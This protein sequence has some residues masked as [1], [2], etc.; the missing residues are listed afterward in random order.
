M[1]LE[2]DINTCGDMNRDGVPSLWWGTSS[3]LAKDDT[4]A[5]APDAGGAEEEAEIRTV[6]GLSSSSGCESEYMVGI[7]SVSALTLSS[8]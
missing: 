4:E 6:T 3:P 1:G 7:V 5:G 8:R 2:G